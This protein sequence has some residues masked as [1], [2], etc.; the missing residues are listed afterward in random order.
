[1]VN[2]TDKITLAIFHET[3]TNNTENIQSTNEANNKSLTID[4]NKRC[5]FVSKK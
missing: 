3:K 5:F 4:K 1:M 2:N